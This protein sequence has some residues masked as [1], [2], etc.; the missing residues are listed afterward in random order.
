[1]SDPQHPC[2][3]AVLRRIADLSAA[4]WDACAGTDNPFVSH[5]FLDAL[6]RSGSA[7]AETG[8]L[9]RHLVAE[10]SAGKVVGRAPLYLKSHS[11]G[12]YVFDWGW[13]EAYHRAGGRYY[14]KLQGAVPFTPVPGPRLPGA[15]EALAGAM[16][17]LARK[18]AVSSV[19]VTFA[20]EDECRLLERHGFLVRTGLQYHWHNR[21]WD[22]FD[23][24]LAALASRKRKQI[25]RERA[26][27]AASGLRLRTLVGREVTS[28]HWDVF[29]RFYA[30]TVDRKWGEA[31]LKRAFFE[32]LSASSLA[33]RVVLMW[34]EDDGRPV[35]AAFNMV[36]GDTL[37]GR[38][39]AA[40]REVPF[41]HFELCYYRAVDFALAH[42]L[43][44]VEAGAQGE[45]K[46]SRGYLPVP[47]WS[48]HWIADPALRRAVARFIDHE[49]AAVR[50]EIEAEAGPY[51][52][53]Q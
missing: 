40:P 31:Y 26:E 27:V 43:K 38:N 7:T 8:W 15:P 10:D 42:G 16:V 37:Y 18:L 48:A 52:Q 20:G 5:A 22:S 36:G 4:D 50:A 30:A 51:R 12:E 9:P 44:R 46:V 25:R 53:A 33:E 39:W 24:F 2:R 17:E 28:H 3:V 47:T 21:G 14:P 34:A 45:H 13:A 41:L 35:A 11:Y 19:H 29:H 49:A 23:D 32:E 6:E 1:M